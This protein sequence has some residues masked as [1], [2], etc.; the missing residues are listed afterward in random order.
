MRGIRFRNSVI[1]GKPTSYD[2]ECLE[3]VNDELASGGRSSISSFNNSDTASA[4][5]EQGPIEGQPES[6]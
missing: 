1:S 6:R 4:L 2:Y 3:K 5:L